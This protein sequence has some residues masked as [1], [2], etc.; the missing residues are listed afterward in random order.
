VLGGILFSA[1]IPASIEKSRQQ[2]RS[3]RQRGMISVVNELNVHEI[4]NPLNEHT[5]V[6][7][8]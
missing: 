2:L 8:D 1:G 3:L 6:D 4:L 5:S 7:V